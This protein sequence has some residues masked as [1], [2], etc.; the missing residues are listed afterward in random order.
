MLDKMYSMIKVKAST[1]VKSRI[2]TSALPTFLT[3]LLVRR[4]ECVCLAGT[5]VGPTCMMILPQVGSGDHTAAG[6]TGL[7]VVAD[8]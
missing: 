4:G 5:T 2:F 1:L 6:A 8:L 7:S 3:A